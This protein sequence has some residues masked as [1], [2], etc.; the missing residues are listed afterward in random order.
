MS[1]SSKTICPEVM[2]F[3]RRMARPSVLLPLPDSPTSPSVSPAQMLSDTPLTA[4]TQRLLRPMKPEPGAG[5]RTTRSLTFSSIGPLMRR[6]PAIAPTGSDRPPHGQR[7]SAASA[8]A[9]QSN[10]L[11]HD[12]SGHGNGSRRA[13]RR[14]RAAGREWSV[15]VRCPRCWRAGIRSGRGCKDDVRGRAHRACC[16]A[17]T[18]DRRTSPQSSRRFAPPRRDRG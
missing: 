7:P 15:A 12:C 9:C 4:C 1:T 6:P 11:L 14:A 16:R 18:G 8:V 5:K 2:S 3:R 17:H 13:V 10:L